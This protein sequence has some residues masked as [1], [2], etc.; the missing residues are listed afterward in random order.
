MSLHGSRFADLPA[1]DPA[2]G[3]F[4]T[5][6]VAGG[7][8]R[9]L[10]AHL[11]RLA[12]SLRTLYA[13]DLPVGV[14]ELADAHAAGVE[15]G[16]LRLTAV[17]QPGAAPVLDAAV[18][19]VARANV[20]PGWELALD[21]RSVAVDGWSGAHKWADRRPLEAL[22]A[23]A[24]PEGALLVDRDGSVLETTRAN[25]FAVGAD[26]VVRTPPLDGRILPGVA[27]ARVLA[28]TRAAGIELREERLRV[29]QLLAAS[30]LFATGSVRGVEPIRSLDGVAVGGP[31]PVSAALAAELR[32]RW[33]GSAVAV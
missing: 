6:L 11:E 20:L 23:R 26:G 15:L 12:A 7:A 16:R 28:L 8:A 18:Q 22:D 25:V 2:C 13:A 17:P 29:K 33:L 1:P 19:P 4:E 24:A 5:L 31:G 21:L 27:R 9:E 14:R 32:A 30:E 10:D 3:V